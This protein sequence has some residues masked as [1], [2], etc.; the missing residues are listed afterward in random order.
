MI[1]FCP[2]NL[3]LAGCP[4]KYLKVARFKQVLV[5]LLDGHLKEAL[6]QKFSSWKGI[7]IIRID[8]ICHIKFVL[9]FSNQ[10][11]FTFVKT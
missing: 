7:K 6:S 10:S 9:S 3:Q 1:L 8:F 11:T 2:C 4:K 5:D